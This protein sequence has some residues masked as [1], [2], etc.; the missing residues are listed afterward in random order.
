M[1]IRE[2]SFFAANLAMRVKRHEDVISGMNDV[3]KHERELTAEERMLFGDGHKNAIKP[4]MDSWKI[5]L[6]KEEEFRGNKEK[7]SQIKE[8]QK[9]LKKRIH[10][11]CTDALIVLEN[12][13][14]P[15]ISADDADAYVQYHTL[16]GDLNRYLAEITIHGRK[17]FMDKADSAYKS[18]THMAV[19]K[20]RRADPLRLGLCL[21]FSVFCDEILGS[22]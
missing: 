21:S 1:N 19:T 13:L 22:R 6:K 2:N 7:I 9:D 4:L 5:L 12:H 20:L 16:K 17:T 8:Y 3:A 10:T 11:I 15:S 14:I 18:A